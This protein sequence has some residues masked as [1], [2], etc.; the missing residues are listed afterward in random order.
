[1]MSLWKQ[2]N[3]KTASQLSNNRTVE[4]SLVESRFYSPAV[5][6]TFDDINADAWDE[7]SL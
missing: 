1:M 3:G 7:H 2:T 4:F 6:D 5:D